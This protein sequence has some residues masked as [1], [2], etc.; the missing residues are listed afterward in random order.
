MGNAEHDPDALNWFTTY[1][2][3][4]VIIGAPISTCQLTVI[5][6]RYWLPSCTVAWSFCVLF[7]YKA[8]NKETLYGLRLVYP[9]PVQH[10]LYEV[11]WPGS[12]AVFLKLVPTLVLFTLYGFFLKDIL[13]IY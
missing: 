1:F 10:I 3:I 7:M 8:E 12:A 13:S 2:S 5:H 4:G 9:R 11:N 6:P